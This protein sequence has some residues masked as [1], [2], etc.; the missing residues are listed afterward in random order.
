MQKDH[1][2]ITVDQFRGTFNRGEDDV[3]PGDHFLDS[4]NVVFTEHGVETRKGTVL[5]FT[6]ADI[7]RMASYKRIG[8]ADRLLILDGT[9]KLWDSTSLA[10]PILTIAEMKDFSMVSLY[11]RAYIT[12]HNSNKGLPG[13][14]IYVYE[15]SGL[16]RPAAGSAPIG[17]PIVAAT[18]STA[19]SVEIGKH[20]FAVAYETISGFLTQPGPA[21]F[22]LYDAPGSK[23]VNLSNIPIGPAGTVARVLLAT[24][25]LATNYAGDAA[26]QEFFSIPNGRLGD[27]TTT[28]AVVDFFDADL[29]ASVDYL[30]DQFTEIPAGVGIGVYKSRMAVWGT[31]TNESAVYFSEPGQPESFS[32]TEGFVLANPGDAS[33]GV[34]NCVEFRSQYYLLKGGGKTYV[35]N[36]IGDSP[37]FWEVTNVDLS[38]GAECHSIAK[39]MDLNGSALDNFFSADRSGLYLFNGTFSNNELSRKIADIW[40]RINRLA[41]NQVEIVHDPI[42]ALIYCAVPLDGADTPTHLL[43]GNIDDGIDP[44]NIRWTTWLFPKN[45]T[46]VVVDLNSLSKRTQFRFGSRQGDIYTYDESALDDFGQAIESFIE[47]AL[48][49]P[50]SPDTDP[51]IYQFG[52]LQIR[53]KGNGALNLTI[54]GIDRAR[55]IQ[56]AGIS[57]GPQPGRTLE[58]MLNFQDERASVKLQTNGATDHFQLTRLKLYA[59]TLW[60]GRVNV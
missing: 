8:E 60:F 41:L 20:L 13:Q 34:K 18:S 46:T 16:A 21:T 45:P 48:L 40:N 2:P 4:L 42:K 23:K 50:D 3:C 19:G 37:A 24:K 28:T 27:N 17:P 38:I 31:D 43:V 33:G 5:N 39:V 22:T 30:M 1:L 12:P 51:V 59:T 57:L 53:A 7:R 58:R 32:A 44:E 49:P 52:H 14:K 11:N 25:K 6:L 29:Q 26:N 54:S 36:E 9:G 35:T 10:S 55:S 47:T 56:P 15:G